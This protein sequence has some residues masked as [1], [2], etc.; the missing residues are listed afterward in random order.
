LSE[1]AEV[2]LGRPRRRIDERLVWSA[3]QITK[4]TIDGP[5]LVEPVIHG[6]ERGFFL[7]SFRAES[8]SSRTT[9]PVRDV[10][11]SAACTFSRGR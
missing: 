7:E 10:R 9:I 11:S 4:V 6:D 1:L 5:L 3:V 8:N 2:S